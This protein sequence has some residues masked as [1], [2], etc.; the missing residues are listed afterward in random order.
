VSGRRITVVVDKT[1]CMG[2]GHCLYAEP[3]VFDQ[4][5]HDGI[6]IL[7]DEH[8][9][10]ELLANVRHAVHTCP[11]QAIAVTVEDAEDG[12]DAP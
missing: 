2:S 9:P 11:A 4:D 3:A 10:E 1:R 6:V 5:D 12:L 7:L 8:P